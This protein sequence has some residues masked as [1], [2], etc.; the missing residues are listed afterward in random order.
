QG[1]DQPSSRNV[2][3]NRSRPCTP[4][5]RLR[6]RWMARMPPIDRPPARMVSQRPRRKSC[7]ASTLAYHSCQVERR[8]SSGVPQWPASWQQKT[9]WPARARAWAMKRSSTGVPPRPWIRRTPTRPPGSNRLRSGVSV[10]I[11]AS[12]LASI[13]MF[14]RVP[15]HVSSHSEPGAS[16]LG[17][18]GGASHAQH[19]RCR[20]GASSRF[21]RQ[22]IGSLANV[23]EG[24][25]SHG[26]T[27][28]ASQVPHATSRDPSALRLCPLLPSPRTPA[29]ILAHAPHDGV[30]QLDGKVHLVPG[31][32]QARR[33]RD[34]VLVV[35][36]DI[37]HE[38][39]ALAVHLQVALEALVNHA[40]DD[41]LRRR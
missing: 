18:A 7:A 32:V 37:E 38:A 31:D 2:G 29:S 22:L 36:A 5:G 25:P 17:A 10:S 4:S 19:R 35:A 8:S 6:A 28:A 41:R 13:V 14:L 34:D 9:V 39:V 30:E 26:N 3:A 11:F 27:T 21:P 1:I 20:L 16:T 23:P 12:A 24:L 15:S 40:V 33:Q